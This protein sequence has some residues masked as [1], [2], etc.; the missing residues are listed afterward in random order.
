MVSHELRTPLNFITGFASILED[1]VSGPLNAEQHAHIER[2]LDGGERLL[3]L[4]ND[5][6]D[7]ARLE[8]GNFRA[9][10]V[11]LALA[12]LVDRV[13]ADLQPLARQRRL[14]LAR[15]VSPGLPVTL[16]DPLRLEQVL[17]NLIGNAIKFTPEGGSVHV[18]AAAEGERVRLS[19]I[20][21]GIGI[22][23]EALPRL[24]DRF[25]QVDSSPTRPF[26]GTGLGLAITRSLI[27]VMNGEI[28]VESEVGK[29]S[30]FW[31]TL[32]KA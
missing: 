23:P 27:E 26:G 28:G 16:A 8:A 13:I 30:T 17:Y 21:T 3:G 7:Y 32:P 29:G 2:I 10:P 19:V 22:P 25:Y 4:V 9:D 20:D 31:F 6:L 24:F 12:P 1:E 5:L 14:T 15:D 11:P 18:A